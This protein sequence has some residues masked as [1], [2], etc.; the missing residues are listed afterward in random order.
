V[1][2]GEAFSDDEIRRRFRLYYGGDEGRELLDGDIALYRERWA[3]LSELMKD[4]KQGF[5]RW[6]NKSR[7][8]RGFFCGEWFKSVLL[9]EGETRIQCLAYIDLNAVRAGIVGRPEEYRWCSLGY[10]L[11]ADNAG[12]FLSL[13]FGLRSFAECSDEERLSPTDR[14]S[15][16]YCRDAGERRT[17]Y[18]RY[19]YEIGSQPSAKGARIDEAI[20]EKEEKK[21][22]QVGGI[23]RL[24]LRTRYFTD[25]GIL[26]TKEFV[27]RHYRRFEDHFTCRHE[28]RPRPIAG[29][30][31][32]YSL[33][34]LAEAVP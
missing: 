4:L 8:R 6:Y 9:E 10:H 5:S 22:F 31:G 24:L 15:S 30:D 26:G 16:A 14:A 32:V 13:D 28:K 17:R 19:V 3:S 33:K 1:G 23:N 2:T 25:S 18:R 12:G 7:G 29:L 27:S 11:Q 20:L 21:G 34:R